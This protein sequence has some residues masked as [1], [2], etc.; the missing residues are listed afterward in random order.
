[1]GQ[2]RAAFAVEPFDAAGVKTALQALEAQNEAFVSGPTVGSA[3]TTASA[4]AGQAGVET[5]LA[6]L[7]EATVAAR[8]G[9]AAQA[10]A[11][12]QA[13]QHNWPSVEAAVATRSPK[14][15]ADTEDSSARA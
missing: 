7:D 6:Q 14:V 11:A 9:D 10:A 4:V 5:L 8:A 1:M 3:P 15:Y 13:F 12:V 2:A